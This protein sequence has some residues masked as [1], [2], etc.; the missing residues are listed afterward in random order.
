MFTLRRHVLCYWL[1]ICERC[2]RMIDSRT[3]FEDGHW[4]M[5]GRLFV[6][7]LMLHAGGCQ[8]NG[9]TP[10]TVQPACGPRPRMLLEIRSLI[11]PIDF[12]SNTHP[13]WEATCEH[14]GSTLREVLTRDQ[15]QENDGRARMLMALEAHEFHC[16]GPGGESAEH[17]RE[18]LLDA[19][20]FRYRDATRH[21]ADDAAAE[22]ARR[23][24]RPG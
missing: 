8:H 4:R 3:L 24:R 13:G 7:D 16:S 12:S 17:W 15:Q 18:R 2:G 20:L 9:V 10:A 19:G 22:R 11:D 5:N 6:R 21:V 14:C 1:A 23:G